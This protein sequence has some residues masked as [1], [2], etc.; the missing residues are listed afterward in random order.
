MSDMHYRGLEV[1]T[2]RTCFYSGPRDLVGCVMAGLPVS[3]I[4]EDDSLWTNLTLVLPLTT[5]REIAATVVEMCDG[6]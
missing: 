5:M 2:Q 6:D 3:P 1:E 4:D